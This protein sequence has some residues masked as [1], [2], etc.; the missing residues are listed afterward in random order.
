MAMG[1]ESEMKMTILGQDVIV[2]KSIPYSRKI[3]AAQEL[4]SRTDV[5]D[6]ERGI[7]YTSY[8]ADAAWWYVRI[9]YYTNADMSEYD[10]VDGLIKMMDE[11]SEEEMATLA[12]YVED[13][14]RTVYAMSGRMRDAAG[15]I[16]KQEHSLAY[17][18]MNSFGFL[19]DGRDITEVMGQAREVN[20]QMIDHLDAIAKLKSD[21]PIDMSQFA[22]KKK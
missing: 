13:D 9:A 21:A 16:F 7:V 22:K 14:W 20:E 10:D 12:E 17:K 15:A 2:Q 3:D 8:L 19:F 11:L 1:K 5:F 18:F 4:A 6:E